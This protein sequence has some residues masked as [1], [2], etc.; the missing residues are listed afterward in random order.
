MNHKIKYLRDKLN[1]QEIQ[2]MIISNPIS[3]YYLTGIKAE[4]TLLLTRK[5]NIF[6]T[7]ARYIEAVNSTLTI[8][9]EIITYDARNISKYD[10]E[11]FFH[12]CHTVGFEEGYVTYRNYKKILEY[13][14]MNNLVETEGI[15]EQQRMI[16]EADEI[17]KIKMACRIT[18]DCFTFLKNDIKIGMKEQEIAETIEKYFKSHG[19]EGTAFSTIVASRTTFFYSS[20]YAYRQ[21]NSSRRYHYD[22]FWMSLSRIYFRHDKNNIC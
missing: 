12:L 3:I 9:D 20:C 21:K 14:K 7:D 4:G 2:G 18:D 19:A 22:R 11:A 10:Y 13:Y 8:D 5:E 16:K 1:S 17:E 6:I 15:I